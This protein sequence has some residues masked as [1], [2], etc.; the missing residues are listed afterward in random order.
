MSNSVLWP[1]HSLNWLKINIFFSSFYKLCVW[2]CRIVS[3][4]LFIEWVRF[5][6]Y[7]R[8][9]RVFK[10]NHRCHQGDKFYETNRWHTI[11]RLILVSLQQH[12]LFQYY[13]AFLFFLIW[14]PVNFWQINISEKIISIN[15]SRINDKTFYPKYSISLFD[16][17]HI[18]LS[19]SNCFF[20]MNGKNGSWNTCL[21]Y[22]SFP[23]TKVIM[24]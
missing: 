2:F 10:S 16:Y 20:E 9:E 4:L 21:W 6:D 18:S 3:F 5:S 19:R 12:W 7:G 14:T 23:L 13:L 15:L 22:Y 8:F 11:T 17:H 24:Y 1:N